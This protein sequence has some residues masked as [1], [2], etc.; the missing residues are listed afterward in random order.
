VSY[1][2][3]TVTSNRN[4]PPSAVTV[5]PTTSG[6]RWSRVALT[7]VDVDVDVGDGSG[8]DAVSS[9]QLVRVVAPTTITAAT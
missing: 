9:P 7:V 8:V 1:G 5:T 2:D 3:E 4:V 6:N